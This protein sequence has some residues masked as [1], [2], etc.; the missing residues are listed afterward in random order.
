MT[1]R[2]K[3]LLII[4]VTLLC[5]VMALYLSLSTIWLNRV[6]QIE[7]Q[8]THQNVERVTEALAN[9]LQEL[10][11]TAKDWAG[12]DDTYAFVEDV[13]EKYIQENLAE[14]SLANLRLNFMVFINRR[15]QIKYGKGLDL[16]QKVATPVPASLKQYIATRPGLLQH[17]TPNSSHRGIL[18]LPEGS[19]LVA[20]Q[21][22][23]KSDRTGS[24]RGSLILG[25]FLNRGELIRLS[26]LTRLPLTIYPFH[27]AQLPQD[28]QA[29]KDALAQ[30]LSDAK[31]FAKSAIIVRPLSSARIAGYTLLRDIEG[32][33]GLLLRV[34]TPRD[35]YQQGKQGLDYLVLAL[36]AV[37]VVFGCVT[38]LLLEKWVLSPL[39]QFSTTV[40]RIRAKGD[41]KERLFTKSRDE[42][43]HLSTAINQLLATLQQSQLQLS[44][45]EERYRSVVNNIQEVIFQ[46]DPA[47]RWTF[48]NPAW[49][50]I[51]G[52]SL[53]ESLGKPCWTFIHL[54][55]QPYYNQ[56]FRRLMEGEIQDTRYELR[57]QTNDGRDRI[58]EVHSR[59][60]VGRCREIAGIAGTL[61]DITERKLAEAR[62]REKAQ[63]LERTLLELTQA[64]SQLIHSEKMSSL[65]QLVAGVAHEINN[66]ISFV[67]GNINHATGYV[68]DILKL[69]NCYQQE[70]PHPSD[71]IR[72]KMQ[73]MD[74][75][76]VVSDLPKLLASMKIGSERIC[77]IVQS[78]Q[79]FSRLNEAEKKRVDIHEGIESTL[80]ILRHKL[81]AKDEYSEIELIK[82]YGKLPKVECYP[83]HLNQVLMNLIANAI[84]ALEER[85]M[86]KRRDS[87]QASP[88][89]RIRTEVKEDY[90]LLSDESS[91]SRVFIYVTDNGAGMTEEV[92]SRLF[93]PFFTTKPIGKG[94][95]LGLSISY[96][97]IVE[98]HKGQLLV[99]S[100]LNQG[101]EFIIE[102]PIRQN[103]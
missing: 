64:Q 90:S 12:W 42:L 9:N 54:E 16:Q 85:R 58:F 75:S 79:N 94:T 36:L 103:D 1:L 56:Q 24:I 65:G 38:L 67:Y 59:L 34:D 80:L 3:T 5:L 27:Q 52:F 68:E 43:S 95:G 44:Q 61:H 10:N 62:E 39:A 40:R 81:K 47:G 89:I 60:I 13:N 71:A 97:I 6:A 92:C 17:S 41:L 48:L 26:Q 7:F 98:K 29:I 15:G 70:Y 72:E 20:S 31:T 96:G 37:G 50:E 8:Q 51:T 4:G 45:S 53:E 21:P 32:Q 46:T 19:L 100:E 93:D 91:I 99:K 25:R 22:I 86:D 83:G 73:D 63:E 78:L 102:L 84:D 23:L 33:P 18:L 76:F 28:F 101:S 30:D 57:F 49:T 11:S 66:P 77:D 74:F 69:I 35:I 88:F 55:D 87:S 14:T 2:Q 82:E